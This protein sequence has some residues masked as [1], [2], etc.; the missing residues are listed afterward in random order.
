MFHLI[1]SSTDAKEAAALALL[2]FLLNERG[3]EV[4]RTLVRIA[5]KLLIMT[6]P[7]TS[8]S[9]K[10]VIVVLLCLFFF[11]LNLHM[12]MYI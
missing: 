7:C 1:T 12:Q 3:D 4:F 5:M 8:S 11:L 10:G 6:L 2:P 9:E